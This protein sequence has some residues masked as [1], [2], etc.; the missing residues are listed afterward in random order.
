MLTCHSPL[1][2]LVEV[3][4]FIA[5]LW[6]VH[7]QVKENGYVQP[8]S[9]GLFR[10]D[11]MLHT[12]N[13]TDPP[14]LKQVE[15]NTI[16]SSFGGLA[17]LVTAL[18]T[19]LATFPTPSS[20]LAYPQHPLL[21][22]GP[23]NG[24][25][26][27][28]PTGVPPPNHAVQILCAG[29]A[30]AHTAYGPSK[31]SPALPLGI[32]F[33]VQDHERN[34]FDQLALS[35]HLRSAHSIPSFRLPASHIL[36]ATATPPSNP[37]RPLL[38]TP[39]SSPSTCYEVSL[40][41]FRALYSPTE[42][43]TPTSWPARHHL[44]RSAAIKCPTVLTHLA[45]SKKVQQALTT[46][47]TLERFLPNHPPSTLTALRSTFAPQ[48]DL[49]PGSD[50]RRLAA[51][52]TTAANH[53]LKPQREGGGNNIYRASIP[54][55]LKSIPETA[56]P[57]YILMELIATP[58]AAKNT[59]LRSDGTV[60]SGNVVSELGIFGACL[61]KRSTERTAA[62]AHVRVGLAGAGHTGIGLMGH[63]TPPEILHNEEGGYL[64]RT[65]AK[66]SNE[67]GVAAGFSALD[68]LILY[69]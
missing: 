15:F 61:W 17:T 29:L 60:V 41:Y 30:A 18:H 54:A 33:L 21:N 67:G 7:L 31:S 38:Y 56:H 66:D 65:K 32:L 13:A 43:S 42:Y 4:D 5:G 68:S 1:F 8:L 47:N 20:P 26:S 22:T 57:G 58:P 24:N 64:L 12:P 40:V 59:V 36:A 45:G 16:S 3:D 6:K 44:E 62:A 14:S 23:R 55:F 10:S 2:R 46:P 34:I 39:P 52:P 53:V 9:L 63:P 25:S 48:Y 27:P 49:A 37:A 69:E 11:Y 51:D 28:K 35:T 19:H 50:G